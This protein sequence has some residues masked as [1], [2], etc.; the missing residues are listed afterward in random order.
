M[1]DLLEIIKILLGVV[2]AIFAWIFLRINKQLN[3]NTEKI[4]DYKNSLVR[5][6]VHYEDI[7]NSLEELKNKINNNN[8]V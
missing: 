4:T 6:E 2:L 8:N 3:S 7:K 5:L 1:F